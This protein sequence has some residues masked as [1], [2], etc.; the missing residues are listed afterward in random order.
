MGCGEEGLKGEMERIRQEWG[1]KK[2]NKTKALQC[3]VML[4]KGSVA[5]GEQTKILAAAKYNLSLHARARR[6]VQE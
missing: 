4:S 2:Q 6:D 3:S 1:G 5:S